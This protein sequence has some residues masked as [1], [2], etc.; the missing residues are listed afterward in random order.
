LHAG[1]W[2]PSNKTGGKNIEMLQPV[3]VWLALEGMKNATLSRKKIRKEGGTDSNHFLRAYRR[4][5]IQKAT[6]FNFSAIF[7]QLLY[8]TPKDTAA[9]FPSVSKKSKIKMAKVLC[10]F[11]CSRN[12]LWRPACL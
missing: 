11:R 2:K 10:V 5:R 8:M 9:H 7:T 3:I 4:F 12:I 6:P 1:T